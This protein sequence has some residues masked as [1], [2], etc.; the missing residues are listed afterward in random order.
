MSAFVINHPNSL[1]VVHAYCINIISKAVWSR[2]KEDERHDQK[3]GMRRKLMRCRVEI[4]SGSRHTVVLEHLTYGEN[5]SRY[6]C[7]GLLC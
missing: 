2:E 6:Y 7:S 1:T 4:K 5:C 3:E